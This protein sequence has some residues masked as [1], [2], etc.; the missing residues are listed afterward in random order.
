[1]RMRT[2][3]RVAIVHHYSGFLDTRVLLNV[4][5]FTVS[6]DKLALR[7]LDYT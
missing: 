1:M 4:K 7:I 3:T 2:C 5:T 6:D